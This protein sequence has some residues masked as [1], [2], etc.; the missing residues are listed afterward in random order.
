MALARVQACAVAGLDGEL[1][2]V[3]VDIARGMPYFSIVGLPDAAVQEA[4]DH[5]RRQ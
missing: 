1:V 4:K 3:E 5:G 2:E